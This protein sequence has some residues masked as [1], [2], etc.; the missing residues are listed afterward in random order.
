MKR[1]IIVTRPAEKSPVDH[2]GKCFEILNIPVTRLVINRE[3]DAARIVAFQPTICIFTSSKG[4]EIFIEL[5]SPGTIS[6]NKAVAIG[7][8]TSRALSTLY[9]EVLVPLEKTS[10]GV[11]DLLDG[12]VT[13]K[14]KI[15]LF[16]SSKTNRVI[17]RHLEERKWSH[18][19]VELYDA[20]ILEVEPVFQELSK[21]EC[22]GIMV[23]SSMEANAIFSKRNSKYLTQ[24]HISG[25]HVFAIGQP[26]AKTL[27]E[28][29]IEISKPV[30]KSD[31]KGLMEE[32]ESLYCI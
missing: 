29:G 28:L 10:H 13:E 11:N 25:K 22:F 15:L 14:D 16:S 2:S 3:I 24:Y 7:E 21:S 4:A 5:F 6:E 30:G 9:K 19:A 17:L 12:I 27:G 31:I 20:E 23:T 8:Q 18:M 32:I 26:T 1:K